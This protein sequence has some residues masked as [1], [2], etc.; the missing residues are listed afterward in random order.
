MIGKKMNT[1]NMYT[2]HILISFDIHAEMGFFKK[3]DINS[4]ICLTYNMLHKPAL[5]G[6]LGAISGL[7]GYVENGKLPEY[8]QIL[9][10][11]KIGI[12][13][14]NSDKGNYTKTVIKY[15]NGTGFANVGILN[16]SEQVLISP[17]FRCYLLLNLD[18]KDHVTLFENLKLGKAEYIPYLGKNEFSAWWSN[19][20]E[21]PDAETFCYDGDF[22]VISLFAKTDA[23]GKY[24]V[25]AMGRHIVGKIDLPFLYFEKLPVGFDEEL[26]QYKYVDFVFSNAV[27]QKDM[28]INNEWQFVKINKNNEVVQLI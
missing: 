28:N 14:L 13:P 4:D 20:V 8:Y 7:K 5:L 9:K 1:C 23:V 17:S 16:I 11:L 21:Y 3:P 15:N 22:K 26:F 25:K 2:S 27:F 18:D 6:I 19:F 12:Q 24:V 10:N